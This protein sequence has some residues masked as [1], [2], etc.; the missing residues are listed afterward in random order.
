MSCLARQEA[1]KYFQQ[2]TGKKVAWTISQ[3]EDGLVRAGYPQ[4]DQE[5]LDFVRCFR[6]SPSYDQ[7]YRKTLRHFHIK[8]KLNGVTVSQALL[9]NNTRVANAMLSLIVDGEDLQRGTWARAMQEGYFYQ[10]LKLAAEDEKVK[11]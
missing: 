5:L 6:D 9:I 1:E 2:M 11:G 10:L 3:P 4:Y 8:P 7:Q